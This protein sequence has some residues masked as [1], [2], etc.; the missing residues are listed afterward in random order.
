M[1]VSCRHCGAF[2]ELLADPAAGAA[3]EVGPEWRS[4]T[5]AAH[6]KKFTIRVYE[7]P[8]ELSYE[9]LEGDSV[10][11][12]RSRSRPGEDEM[13]LVN[14]LIDYVASRLGSIL[15]DNDVAD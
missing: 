9:I 4:W 1:V 2:M 13:T 12:A 8:P 3:S 5:V 14:R 6:G 11:M 7:S 15:C 10:R